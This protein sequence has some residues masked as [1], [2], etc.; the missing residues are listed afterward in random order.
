MKNLHIELVKKWLA[1]PKSVSAEELE[2]ADTAAAVAAAVSTA[3][4]N[5][6]SYA[7]RADNTKH[8][9]EQHTADAAAAHAARTAHAKYWLEKYEEL[10]K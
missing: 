6:A 5:A 9:G 4:A 10:T 1:D 2:R 8:W 3:V 7:A